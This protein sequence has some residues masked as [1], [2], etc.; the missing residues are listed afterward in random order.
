MEGVIHSAALSFHQFH[1]PNSSYNIGQVLLQV[2][3]KFEI[4]Q[5]IVGITTNNAT[6][7]DCALPELGKM[8]KK[9]SIVFNP[10]ISP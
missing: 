6:N 8:L 10:E 4:T 5:K 7:K 2:L 1:S 9:R 3:D